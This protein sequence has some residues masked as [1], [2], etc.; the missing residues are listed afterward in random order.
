MA[1]TLREKARQAATELGDFTVDDL[2]SVLNIHTEEDLRKIRVVVKDLKFKKEIV[3][4]RR[5]FYRFQ[6]KQKPLSKIAKM[7]RAMRIKE[8]FTRQDIKRLSGASEV[9]VINY[10]KYLLGKGFISHLSGSGF[11]ERLYCL[12][13]PEKAPLHHPIY[14]TRDSKT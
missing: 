9:Y 4:L 12:N 13:D 5:G 7:W 2:A 10:F 3:S 1:R 6:K 11:K 14:R 8:Y